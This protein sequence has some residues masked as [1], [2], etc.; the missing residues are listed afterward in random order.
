M[1]SPVQGSS[2]DLDTFLSYSEEEFILKNVGN[3]TG[4]RLSK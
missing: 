2:I 4:L 1:I 3:Q